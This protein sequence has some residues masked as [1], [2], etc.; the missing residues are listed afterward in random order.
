MKTID[1]QRSYR[2]VCTEENVI[3]AEVP[4]FKKALDMAF[5]HNA[6][7]LI[8]HTCY[9]DTSRIQGLEKK[10]ENGQHISTSVY[11]QYRVEASL[12]DNDVKKEF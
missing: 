5:K 3:L 12:L 4:T 6:Q 7:E 9:F 1:I 8:E 2:V 11:S 10:Y